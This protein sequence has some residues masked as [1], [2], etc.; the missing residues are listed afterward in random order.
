MKE[1]KGI[2]LTS[3]LKVFLA[4]HTVAIVLAFFGPWP[5]PYPDFW[6][7]LLYVI[8]GEVAMIAGY[9]LAV[10]KPKPVPAP[11]SPLWRQA[12][13]IGCLIK[14]VLFLPVLNYRT[15][16]N[17][18]IVGA[19]YDP[20]DAYNQTQSAEVRG[21]P[22]AEKVRIYTSPI[23]SAAIP[24]GIAFWTLFSRGTRLL[25]AI[26][27]ILDALL[28]VGTGTN[29]GIAD[30]IATLPWFAFLAYRR[31]NTGFRPFKVLIAGAVFLLISIAFVDFFVRGG[32]GRSGAEAVGRYD[33]FTDTLV[34]EEN[35][36]TQITPQP[37]ENAMLR[38]TV[39]L[40]QGFYGLSL[41]LDQPFNS[42]YGV[43]HSL[44]LT[45]YA[46]K[47]TGIDIFS[48]TT[49]SRAEQDTGYPALLRW[50]SIYPWFAN[51]V[52]FGGALVV[53]ALLGWWTA[54]AWIDA[55]FYNPAAIALIGKLFLVWYYLSC[56][57]QIAQLSEDY[58]GLIGLMLIWW[59]S[60]QSRRVITVP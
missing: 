38:G 28:W 12:V 34:D 55:T 39:Y 32:L 49:V 17:A 7:V 35:W 33:F 14:I 53:I 50:H 29:K 21:Y 15:S 51:D 57:N 46:S 52:G 37:L 22:F 24:I 54:R 3:P 31:N 18:N 36:V 26:A 47:Y 2:S 43:G 48:R 6:K 44:F 23:H 1:N 59:R 13:L 45:G 20:G 5:W 19:F 11:L 27:T 40:T 9:W 60:R 4:V 10:R 42:C 58:I 41:C 56:N 25:I 8:A 30:F 16:G